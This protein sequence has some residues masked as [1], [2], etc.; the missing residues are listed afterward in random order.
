MAV[1]Q[2][3]NI[4]EFSRGN[5]SSWQQMTAPIPNGVFVYSLD[6]GN[7]KFGNGVDVY[8][9]LPVLFQW[10]D[11]V[12][13]KDGL[14][15]LFATFDGVLNDN[16]IVIVSAG[17]YSPSGI[18][19]SSLLTDLANLEATNAAQTTDFITLRDILLNVD[20]ASISSAPNDNL[21]SIIGGKYSDSGKT[22][23]DAVADANLFST[24]NP[25][26]HLEG[27]AWYSDAACT[28][29]V[30]SDE[31]RN[32]ST[33]YCK[34]S[35][36]HDMTDSPVFALTCD[37]LA[38]TV[39]ATTDPVVYKVVFSGVNPPTDT[40]TP[41]IFHASVDDGSGLATGVKAT[42][43]EVLTEATLVGVYGGTG[44]DVF[45]AVITDLDGNLVCAGYTDSEGNGLAEAL[46]VK[47]DSELNIVARKIYGGTGDDVFNDVAID[48]LGNTIC[49]GYTTSEG[50]GVADALVVKFDSL[51]NIVSSKVYG[52]AGA[53]VFSDVIVESND[54]V[55][56]VGYT[57]SA[58]SGLEDAL[59]VRFDGKLVVLAAKVH[60]GLGQ[61]RFRGIMKNSLGEIFCAG[62][63][64]SEGAG[65]R[66]ALIV[67]FDDALTL[68]A[69]RVFGGLDDDHFSAISDYSDE[70]LCVGWTK[71]VGSGLE[72]AL[73]VKLDSLL[74]VVVSKVYGGAGN[75]WLTAVV[76]DSSGRIWT[77]GRQYSVLGQWVSSSYLLQLDSALNVI[78]EKYWGQLVDS[79]VDGV[80][81]GADGNVICTG[82]CDYAIITSFPQEL[83]AGTLVSAVIPDLQVID[84]VLTLADSLLTIADTTTLVE[85]DAVLTNTDS[86][87]TLTDSALLS[88]TDRLV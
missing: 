86:A 4:T 58:G 61:D 75:E 26:P 77:G 27:V 87:L 80:S 2:I 45:W 59:I 1:K 41:V 23:A 10:D 73:I 84:G 31:M 62:W 30:R 11:L 37:N 35:G 47:F 12:T 54:N 68:L 18:T 64:T 81:I 7:F 57:E 22:A 56:C 17:K 33:F 29:A 19:L 21:I 16:E 65:L 83:P 70:V 66:D 28:N 53:D 24:T 14:S 85:I 5:E 15:T 20:G 52:G 36:F 60:G 82:W 25:G 67:K 34:V 32:N 13:A 76:A 43:I 44:F 3:L 6:D 48:S 40:K 78:Q 71:S 74:N 39:T 88:L 69:S 72:D 42:V 51:L 50:A 9:A 55:L 8:G 63:T 79:A 38:V 49:V 46:I